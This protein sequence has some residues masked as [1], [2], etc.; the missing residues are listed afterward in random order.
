MTML[1]QSTARAL[2]ERVASGAPVYY[3][4]VAAHD[5]GPP[6]DRHGPFVFEHYLNTACS[7]EAA[8]ARAE[9]A[10]MRQ[11]GGGRLARLD[12][13]LQPGQESEPH[14]VVA[15]YDGVHHTKGPLVWETYLPTHDR[16]RAERAA[17]DIAKRYGGARIAR[18]TYTD[19]DGSPL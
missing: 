16:A 19:V 12:F 3:I 13:D 18:V 11:C 17:E 1:S 9:C 15:D 7:R 4:A 8:A 5:G 6:E 2:I 14:V 10:A